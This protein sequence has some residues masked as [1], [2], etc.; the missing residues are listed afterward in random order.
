MTARLCIDCG[1][2]LRTATM[3]AQRFPDSKR[4]AAGGKCFSCYRADRIVP[5]KDGE[6]VD[7]G[8]RYGARPTLAN[9]LAERK[10]FEAGR[11][12]RGIPPEGI[13]GSRYI[14]DAP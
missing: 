3:S 4:H 10:A 14:D 7:H 2:T 6:K 8:N 12:A 13:R 5:L 9:L 1:V 11:R